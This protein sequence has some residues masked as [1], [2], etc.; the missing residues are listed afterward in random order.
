MITDSQR[1]F[2]EISMGN[3]GANIMGTGLGLMSTG[4]ATE[5]GPYGMWY[6]GL[7]GVTYGRTLGREM[8]RIMGRFIFNSIYIPFIYE[9][10]LRI[11]MIKQH[12]QNEIDYNKSFVPDYWAI[13]Y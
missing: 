2:F 1:E 6:S 3:I 8:G 5:L 12:L 10:I 7:L 13:P 9:P 4:C 11:N